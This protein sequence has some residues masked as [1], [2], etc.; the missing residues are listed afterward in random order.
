MQDRRLTDTK[1]KILCF[2]MILQKLRSQSKTARSSCF[3]ELVGFRDI[4]GLFCM[5]SSDNILI[6]FRA[7]KFD[8]KCKHLP[9]LH[10]D[11]VGTL[12]V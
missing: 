5:L 11:N 7:I 3:D 9:F 4:W 2:S 10:S 8:M 6:S 12:K 1:N